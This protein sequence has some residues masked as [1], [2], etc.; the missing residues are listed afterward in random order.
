MIRRPPRS[1]LFPYPTLFRSKSRAAVV[2][3]QR[4]AG[5]AQAARQLEPPQVSLQQFEAAV[6]R[7]LLGHELDRQILLDHLPQGAYAQAHQRGLRCWGSNVGAFSLLITQ[8]ALLIHA[9]STIPA[10]L[11]SDWGCAPSR[12]FLLRVK[13]PPHPC[14]GDA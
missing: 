4:R 10:S 12:A 3:A 2:P 8:E 9:E 11:F 13:V 6:G 7:E 1:T 5:R 14:R